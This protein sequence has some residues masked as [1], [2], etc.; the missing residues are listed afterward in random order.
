MKNTSGSGNARISNSA[1]KR[2]KRRQEVAAQKKKKLI[3]RCIGIAVIVC[4]CL[5][6]GYFIIDEV[7]YRM[8]RT[9]ASDDYSAMLTEDGKLDGLDMSDYVVDKGYENLVVPFADVEYTD[10]E[11]D[12]EIA[13]LLAANPALDTD[14]SLTVADG[15]QINL[16]HVGYLDG[17][18]FEGGDTQGNGADL[19]IG[20]GS[21]IDDFETQ[22]IGTHP[23]DTVTVE[24][25]FPD[26]YTNNPDLA[27]QD[28]TF[29]V[30][31]NGIYYT[32]EFDDAFVAEHLSEYA[33][34][35]DEYREYL[36]EQNYLENLD[37]YIASYI[38]NNAELTSYPKAYINVLKSLQK[39]V[40]EYNYNFYNEYYTSMIGSPAYSS[41]TEYTGMSD[42]N[43]EKDLLE[44]ARMA[45]TTN[46]TY[47][48]LFEKYNLTLTDELYAEVVEKYGTDSETIYGTAY[49]N[50]AA[51][52]EAVV[53][54]LMTVVTVE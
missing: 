34:T 22:L 1:A 27:G 17:V 26:T 46:M 45:A 47:Q 28:A 25:T 13:E 23:G 49:L 38:V 51:M 53:D 11:L 30:T 6:I 15:D 36:R 31:I 5:T 39:H 29:E 35:A 20:S 52:K 40:D 24:V 50:Q 48:Y 37:T 9:T 21:Y 8:N 32:P 14:P 3:S 41:F 18:A 12:A 33:S 42:K 43:Y 7:K 54:Y 19:T 16:D 2:E 10:E 4:L 44:T